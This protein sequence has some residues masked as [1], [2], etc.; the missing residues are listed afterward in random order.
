[1]AKIGN[2]KRLWQT[3]YRRVRREEPDLEHDSAYWERMSPDSMSLETFYRTYSFAVLFTGMK[4]SVIES[5]DEEIAAAL[6]GFNID[7][8]AENPEG[9]RENLLNVFGHRQKA[10][11]I[12]STALR[13]R[14]AL[15]NG[16]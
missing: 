15:G 14:T 2:V 1:M 11:A 4:V 12:I 6:F 10:D 9:A 7:Q 5:L 8:I 16:N 13:P 3:A